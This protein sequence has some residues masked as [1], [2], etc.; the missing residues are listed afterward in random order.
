MP[1]HIL[2]CIHSKNRNCFLGINP[3]T[4][5]SNVRNALDFK[6][7]IVKL[8]MGDNQCM[9]FSTFADYTL[10]EGQF[11]INGFFA[12]K[13]NIQKD[14][15]YEID[16]QDESIDCQSV[17]FSP[18]SVDD[19]EILQNNTEM[20]E[21]VFL[22][23]IRILSL[24]MI[25][26]IWISGLCILLRV[27]QIEP[28]DN[29]DFSM[30]SSSTRVTVI[31]EFREQSIVQPEQIPSLPSDA[32]IEPS[33]SLKS[34]IR[35]IGKFVYSSLPNSP[36]ISFSE[37][38]KT[39]S[40]LQSKSKLALV[41]GRH[42]QIFRVEID[43][44]TSINPTI[45]RINRSDW[46]S[47]DDDGTGWPNIFVAKITVYRSSKE[48][49]SLTSDT[50]PEHIPKT[51][52]LL[53]QLTNDNN[54]RSKHI[55]LNHS[56]ASLNCIH[57]TDKIIVCNT[58]RRPR[59]RT[60]MEFISNQGNEPILLLQHYFRV[61]IR[62]CL[63][64]DQPIL[65][66]HECFVKLNNI[67]YQIHLSAE[68]EPVISDSPIY[69]EINEETIGQHTFALEEKKE[70]KFNEI[71]A[72]RSKLIVES[73][74]DQQEQSL[75]LTNNIDRLLQI[76]ELQL[77][78]DIKKSS[79][80]DY[81]L[82]NVIITGRS[83]SGKKTIVGEC[84]QRLWN[85]HLIYYK[86]VDCLSFKGRKLDNIVTSFSQTIDEMIF[87]QPSIL[88]LD[89]FDDL[90]PN[91]TAITDANIILAT[92]K[93]SLS[94]RE[95]FNRTQQIHK[96]FIIIP[97]V[98]QITNIHR[99]F[100]EETPLFAS[101]ILTIEPLNIIQRTS[102]IKQLIENKKQTI[103][104]TLL[105]SIVNRTES[106]VI[107]DLYTLIDNALLHSWMSFEDRQLSNI[108]FDYAFDEF[109]PISVK[110]L[111]DDKKKTSQITLHWSDIGGMNDLKQELIQTVQWRFEHSNYFANAPIRL[112]SGV[113]LYGPSGCGKTLLAQTLANECKVNFIQI[114]G[115]ELLNKYVGSSEQNIRDLFNRARSVTPC[116][117]LFDEFEALV[118]RRGRDSAGV[119]DRVVNQLLTELDGVESL[120]D[121]VVIAATSR[122]D[123]IDPALLRPGRLDKHLYVG[124]PSKLDIVS[125][126]KIWTKKIQ[127]ANNIKFE[128]ETFLS[129]CE[130]YTGADIKALVY[131]AQLAAFDEYQ[132]KQSIIIHK[133]HLM[134]AIKQTP[135]SIP[136]HMRNANE[137]F[138]QNWRKPIAIDRQTTS[139]A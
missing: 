4:F 125:I 62:Q 55:K 112:I 87:R 37:P 30:I 53:I 10:T 106:F 132:S 96:Q 65:I 100:T 3:R 117:I 11:S 76:L 120:G 17:I 98:K 58:T 138:Y 139:L 26:P 86:L 115:P 39:S 32:F 82:K 15:F 33:K 29:I 54:C 40:D 34:V 25:F 56:F 116:I 14:Q 24:N 44:T 5:N 99:Q 47:D 52:F 72:Y 64:N 126:L 123:L 122:P 128:D 121:I 70:W 22:N 109:K 19:W 94:I 38:K 16:E 77:Q 89:H 135:Y 41:P 113:L 51:Y 130:M 131:N 27:V 103:S 46:S 88:I 9:Y 134:S 97:I 13:I 67:I 111:D 84:C 92:Q 7:S 90:F 12:M 107:K 36:M 127:L 1:S 137:H 136:V 63:N 74:I 93:L 60:R 69:I 73:F 21:E 8:N 102:I 78:I 31:P 50:L 91:E 124:F 42:R 35:S 129:H 28:N 80:N 118:P 79:W 20:T 23:Q 68:D 18:V 95:L 66:T 108:D 71:E 48:I 114:K 57:P 59:N 49:K 85:K 61:W 83:G 43:E 104:E 2:R 45:A 110:L 119:T 101:Q 105:H 81:L 75:A 133:H 6:V